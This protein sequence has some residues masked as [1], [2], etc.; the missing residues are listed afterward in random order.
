MRTANSR[1][2]KSFHSC[3]GCLS[4][5]AF[6]LVGRATGVLA[7]P[8]LSPPSAAVFSDALPGFNQALAQEVGAQVRAAGYATEF[9]SVAVLTNQSLLTAKRYDLLVLPGARSLPIA[10]APASHFKFCM[11]V[12]LSAARGAVL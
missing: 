3:L 12:L 5:L 9:V 1:G 7:P 6:L 4:A 2:P 10:A 11:S 8:V